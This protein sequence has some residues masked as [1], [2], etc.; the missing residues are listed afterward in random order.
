M[1]VKFSPTM[2]SMETK[3]EREFRSQGRDSTHRERSWRSFA[4]RVGE[5]PVSHELGSAD[6]GGVTVPRG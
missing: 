4:D 5:E 3:E 1:D 2:G 6:E